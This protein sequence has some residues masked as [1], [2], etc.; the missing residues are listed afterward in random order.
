MTKRLPLTTS[1]FTE[2]NA[3]RCLVVVLLSKLCAGFSAE[4]ATK[5]VKVMLKY[6][7]SLFLYIMICNYT[8]YPLIFNLQFDKKKICPWTAKRGGGIN[9]SKIFKII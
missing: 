3:T 6:V 8:K 4:S 1:C 2:S 7:M 9:R 5:K